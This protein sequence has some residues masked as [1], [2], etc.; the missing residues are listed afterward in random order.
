M[1]TQLFSKLVGA[2]FNQK[3]LIVGGGPSVKEIENLEQFDV[4]IGVNEHALRAGIPH[5][6]IVAADNIG[7]KIK[8]AAN[9]AEIPPVITPHGFGDIQLTQFWNAG[10][11]GVIAA[12]VAYAMGANQIAL[13]GM[14]CYSPDE[15]GN[16]ATYFWEK[17][18]ENDAYKWPFQHHVNR[19]RELK[20]MRAKGIECRVIGN[21]PLVEI[22]G[23]YDAAIE[24]TRQHDPEL[25]VIA[26]DVDGIFVKFTKSKMVQGRPFEKGVRAWIA[27]E[28]INNL[29]M[30]NAIEFLDGEDVAA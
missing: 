29:L 16:K 13:A 22:F 11:S 5:D 1:T 25:E 26:Q 21:G 4:V 17:G 15:K 10:S 19:W 7:E 20:E 12:W 28:H 2:H 24:L 27:R 23:S 6:Y 18:Q 3:F 8:S 30:V 14:D 9:G